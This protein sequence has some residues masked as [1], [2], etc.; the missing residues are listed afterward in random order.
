MAEDA[1]VEAAVAVPAV[2][3]GTDGRGSDRSLN[4]VFVVGCHRSGTNLLYDTLLSA[5][6][7]AFYRGYLPIYKVVI[8]RCGPLHVAANRGKAI[9]LFL[10][11]KGFRRA[12]LEAA[13]LSSR[14]EAECRTGGDFIRIVMEEIARKQGVPRWA[15]YDPDYV[16][17]VERIKRDLP[18]ALFLHIVRDGRDIALSLMK[19][20]GFR[21]FPWSSKA[22]GLLET[23][24]YWEWMVRRGQHYGRMFPDSYLE[25]HYEEL[26]NE[27]KKALAAVSQFIDQDLDYDHIQQAGVGRLKESNSSFLGE[28]E[29]GRQNPVNRWK[30]RLSHQ[31]VV[32]I[33]SLVGGCLEDL[34]YPLTTAPAER[35]L[36]ARARMMHSFYT[37]FLDGK[38]WAKLHT[39]VGRFSNMSVLDLEGPSS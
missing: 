23:A 20:G 16:L 34:G 21:P 10:R 29:L 5:G 17:H 26:V 35:K 32:A 3:A 11:S 12:G 24:V 19:M 15:V 38:L 25:V 18:N 22:R 4:P 27:P 9:E 36:G 14:L 37:H 13:G 6:G 39:P 33:E 2:R 8:P 31:E 28:Q 7:F 30:E 1:S